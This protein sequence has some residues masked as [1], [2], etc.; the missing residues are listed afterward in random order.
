MCLSVLKTQTFSC[1]AISLST[2][3]LLFLAEWY[4]HF[5]FS[6]CFFPHIK[7]KYNTLFQYFENYIP[8]QKSDIVEENGASLGNSYQTTG[9]FHDI[10][11]HVFLSRQKL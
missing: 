1:I 9:I 5:F 3:F 2:Y 10:L 11:R 7:F 4:S 6:T 8:S